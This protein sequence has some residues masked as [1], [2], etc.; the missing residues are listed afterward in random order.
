MLDSVSDHV[1]EGHRGPSHAS[2]YQAEPGVELTDIEAFRHGHPF[3]TYARLRAEAPVCWTPE[4]DDRPGFWAVTRYAEVAA[5]NSDPATYSSQRGSM[6]MA[7][8]RPEARHRLLFPASMNTMINLDGANHMQLRREHMP[9]FTPRYLDLLKARVAAETTRLLNAME[10]AAQDGVVDMVEHFSSRLPLFTLCEILGVPEADRPKVLHWMHYLELAE[11]VA[12]DQAKSGGAP[13][14]ELMQ[15]VMEFN[16]NV[17][18]MFEYGRRMLKLRRENPQEDLM[19]AIARAQ[20][21]GEF[22]SDEFLDGSWLLIIFAG[23]DTTRNTLSGTARLL[24]EFPDQ[25]RRLAATPDLLGNAANEFIRM[26]SPVIYMRRTATKDTVLAG[27]KIARDEKVIMY[28]GAANRDP[29]VFA[30][31]DVLDVGRANADKHL[32]FGFGPHVCLGKRVAQIQL[33]EAYRQ[34]LARFPDITW[35]GDIDIAPN[36]FVHAIRR[37]PVRLRAGV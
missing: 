36:N 26:V 23:N 34:I 2:V 3:A 1:V 21:D 15:F 13:T 16:E 33:E 14:L 31:P 20:V 9:Y 35:T 4:P 5:V 12:T 19:S 28:Y 22:L 18:E 27:Q 25:R 10:A 8:G 17:E 7:L 11:K 32:A 30:D 24:T 29:A 37:L 6:L